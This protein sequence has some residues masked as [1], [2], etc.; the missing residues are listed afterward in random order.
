MKDI[1]PSPMRLGSRIDT[2][3]SPAILGS[4]RWTTLA[5]HS[6]MHGGGLSSGRELCFRFVKLALLRRTLIVRGHHLSG[7]P[8]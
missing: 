2:V 5:T 1:G 8:V 7:S 4:S 3:A 6:V